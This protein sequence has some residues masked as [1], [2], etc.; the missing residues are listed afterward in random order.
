M[1]TELVAN[2]RTV[3]CVEAVRSVALTVKAPVVPVA[4]SLMSLVVGVPVPATYT[5]PRSV[6]VAPPS[7]VTLPPSVA[8][9]LMVLA[10]AAVVTVGAVVAVSVNTIRPAPP[11]PVVLK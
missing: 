5:T 7:A 8:L 2:A 4:V 1:P 10:G 3:Y 9:V 11:L 6:M